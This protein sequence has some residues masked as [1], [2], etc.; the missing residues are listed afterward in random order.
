[1]HGV[2]IKHFWLFRGT[3][4]SC[5]EIFCVIQLMLRSQVCNSYWLPNSFW[6]LLMSCLWLDH[7]L[8]HHHSSLAKHWWAVF[9]LITFYHV[10]TAGSGLA[11]C[12]LWGIYLGFGRSTMTVWWSRPTPSSSMATSTWATLGAWSSHPSLTAATWPSPPPSTF[13]VVAAPRDL[14]EPGR[15]RPPRIWAR[16]W[17]CMSL[18]STAP[19]AWTTNPWDACSPVWH[20]WGNSGPKSSRCFKGFQPHCEYFCLMLR[21]G[22]CMFYVGFVMALCFIFWCFILWIFKPKSCL[23]SYLQCVEKSNDLGLTKIL[24]W[25]QMAFL[26]IYQNLTHSWFDPNHFIILP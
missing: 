23:G 15:R 18:S 10:V 4:L 11:K 21:V 24:Q 26:A 13:T 2:F 8:P 16:G 19:R 7:I 5:G 3:L 17:A 14:P 12:W 6:R 20:R 25:I 9:D 22:S 1:M